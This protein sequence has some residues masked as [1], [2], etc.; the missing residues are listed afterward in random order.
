M[1]RF[2]GQMKKTLI[3]ILSV[4]RTDYSYF[5]PLLNEIKK[6]PGLE[7]FLIAAGMHLSPKFGMTY[8]EIR[9]D[10]FRIDK[11]IHAT[12]LSN[13][14]EATAKTIGLMTLGL[15]PVLKK[16]I[17][18]VLL[19]LGDRFETL[20]A[21]SAAI[22]YNTPI[23]HVCG[24]DLTEGAI[25][26]QIRHAITKIS[27]LHFVSNE[28]SRKRVLQMG[29]EAWRVHN[30]GSPCVDTIKET[31]L[32]S[33]EELFKLYDL[34]PSKKLFLVTYHPVTLEV[35]NTRSHTQNL[36]KALRHFDANIIATY[37]N[38]DHGS[39]VIVRHF[40]QLEKDDKKFRFVKSLGVKGYYSAMKF[41]D[42]MIGNSSSGIIESI[43]FKLP[44][45][46]IGNRQK[47]RLRGKNVLNPGYS[48][49]DIIRATEKALSPGFRKSLKNLKN[50]YGEGETSRKIVRIIKDILRKK[51]RKEIITKK[52]SERF[53]NE[54]K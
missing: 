23:A 18:D 50:P 8:K 52:F 34:D 5:R 28:L 25:D 26:E 3:G 38:S 51:S 33:K 13:T 32:Y 2:K 10:G 19:V 43:A 15:I 36:I 7:Y 21:V 54:P 39:A 53:K 48:S 14:P 47:G 12:I 4:G 42:A 9:K 20:G 41:S 1:G 40:E 11:R 49:A 45:V 44:V 6:S 22:P 46:D 35:E 29:E 37:P 30:V 31:K 16:G 27:H 17:L 24:G